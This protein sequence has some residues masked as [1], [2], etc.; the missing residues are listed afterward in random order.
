M[1]MKFKKKN[2]SRCNIDFFVR[3]N[4]TAHIFK[5]IDDYDDGDNNSHLKMYCILYNIE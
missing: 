5:T 3:K 4:K 2:D 1:E